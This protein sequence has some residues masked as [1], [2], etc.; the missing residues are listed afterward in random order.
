[1]VTMSRDDEQLLKRTCQ[2]E[3]TKEEIKDEN[4]LFKP[5]YCL[6]QTMTGH[7]FGH[8]PTTNVPFIF[9]RGQT[10]WIYLH[11]QIAGTK[12]SNDAA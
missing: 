7:S 11:L 2:E 10:L 3:P 1:M 6:V 8:H 5:V 4:V 9:E 12:Y